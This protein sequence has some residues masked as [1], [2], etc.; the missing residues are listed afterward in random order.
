VNYTRG[1]QV[2]AVLV[3]I[4]VIVNVIGIYISSS[5]ADKEYKQRCLDWCNCSI[6]QDCPYTFDYDEVKACDCK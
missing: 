6:T 1:L 4:F 3:I 5:N 2:F